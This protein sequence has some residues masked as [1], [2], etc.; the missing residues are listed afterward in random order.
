MQLSHSWEGPT[1]AIIRKCQTKPEISSGLSHD[2][3]IFFLELSTFT[4]LHLS[5][6]VEKGKTKDFYLTI[7][8]YFIYFLFFLNIYIPV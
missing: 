3:A 1:G 5:S 4:S 7:G 6:Y 2:Y 8:Y